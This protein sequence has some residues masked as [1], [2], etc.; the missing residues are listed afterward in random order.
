MLPFLT[1]QQQPAQTQVKTP[2]PAEMDYLFDI[3]GQKVKADSYASPYA[4][5]RQVQ[6][7]QQKA[8]QPQLPYDQLINANPRNRNVYNPYKPPRLNMAKGG[9]MSANIDNMMGRKRK[10]TVEDLLRLIG[11]K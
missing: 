1:Q 10:G 9:I 5:T 4:V 7:Q 2:P 8:A 11:G 6:A 3:T